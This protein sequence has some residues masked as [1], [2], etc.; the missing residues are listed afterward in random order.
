MRSLSLFFLLLLAINEC[1]SAGCSYTEEMMSQNS[2]KYEHFLKT[3]IKQINNGF[4]IN[5]SAPS[6]LN[7]S[8]LQQAYIVKFDDS[9]KKEIF[10][11][12]ISM[13]EENMYLSGWFNIDASLFDNIFLYV[14]YGKGCGFSVR[15][16]IEK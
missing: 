8:E 13:Y 2:K 14:D 10:V 11:F 7:D 6:L 5:I 12:P 4:S 1:H 3:N 15:K 9:N 16:M